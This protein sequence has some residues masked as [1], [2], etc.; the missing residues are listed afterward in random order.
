M[1]NA[2]EL[3]LRKMARKKAAYQRE[4]EELSNRPRTPA[5]NWITKRNRE[6][7]AKLE[8][9][10][11]SLDPEDQVQ[12]IENNE[13]VRTRQA[14]A[15][16]SFAQFLRET[17]LL[18]EAPPDYGRNYRKVDTALFIV[19][20]RCSHEAIGIFY[21]VNL[22]R[23]NPELY[24]VNAERNPK[25]YARLAIN[26]DS[27]R[28]LK[29]AFHMR[30]RVQYATMELVVNELKERTDIKT[31]EIKFCDSVRERTVE[32]ILEP[33]K[34]FREIDMSGSTSSQ[35]K[36]FSIEGV[37]ARL[38]P[39]CNLSK[40]TSRK[41]N[42]DIRDYWDNIKEVVEGRKTDC[43]STNLFAIFKKKPRVGPWL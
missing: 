14:T 31:L 36:R 42:Q 43:V 29:R 6:L 3:H 24:V 7:I 39:Y 25:G 22:I 19:N 23:I 9:K 8:A 38:D 35:I 17:E 10:V 4:I 12:L 37:R 28:L 16:L 18:N 1:R 21:E 5:K 20:R 15:F 30:V 13:G 26:H 2:R 34:V 41:C 11:L 32:S 27:V 33:F 40:E